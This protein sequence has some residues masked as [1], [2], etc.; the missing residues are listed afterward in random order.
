MKGG[1]FGFRT[2]LVTIRLIHHRLKYAIDVQ[3]SGRTLSWRHISLYYFTVIKQKVVSP[4]K[5]T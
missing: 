2:A 5:S 3:L 4:N 1:S